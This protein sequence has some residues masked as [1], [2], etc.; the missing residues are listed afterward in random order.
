MLSK[1]KI[2]DRTNKGLNV[3]KHYI[4]FE[5]SISKNFLN[6]LYEDTKASC[7]VY[8]DRRSDQYKLKDYGNDD[9]SGDCFHFVGKIIGIDCRQAENFAEILKKINRDLNLNLEESHFN[10]VA[11]G[12]P[13]QNNRKIMLNKENNTQIEV[14]QKQLKPYSVKT[15]PFSQIELDFWNQY[16]ITQEILRIYKVVS[17]REFQSENNQGK[18]YKIFFSEK[19]PIFAYQG[20]RFIKLYRPVSTI[21]FQYAGDTA[22]KYCF[23]LII[24]VHKS[25]Q[26]V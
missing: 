16:G 20:K 23:G 7:N 25:L 21:R 26:D 5:F 14:E 19:E 2:L 15:K 9:Y 11:K 3:F 18:P 12:Y 22:D 24:C 6:P 8:F 1:E 13:K 17:I 4:P 10:Q